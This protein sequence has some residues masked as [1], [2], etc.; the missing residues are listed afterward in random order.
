MCDHQTRRSRGFGFVVFDSEQVVDELLAKG[1]MIDLAGSKVSLVHFIT[2]MSLIVAS[3]LYTYDAKPV[4]KIN[5]KLR[6]AKRILFFCS[7]QQLC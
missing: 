1:N 3:P 4:K 7:C 6:S 2:G 5:I